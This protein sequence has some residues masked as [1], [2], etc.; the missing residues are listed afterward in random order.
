MATQPGGAI[1]AHLLDQG[2]ATHDAS[3][4]SPGAPMIERSL[5]STL[6]VEA[7]PQQ[8]PLTIR[9]LIQ[10][11]AHDETRLG[12]VDLLVAFGRG[13]R[14]APCDSRLDRRRTVA[15]ARVARLLHGANALTQLAR[16]ILRA[17]DGA[18]GLNQ[19]RPL[20]PDTRCQLLGPARRSHH[21]AMITEVPLQD[22]GDG[23]HGERDE[24]T[25]LGSEALGSLNQACASNLKQVLFVLSAVKKAP[26][27][28]LREP[29]V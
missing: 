13:E 1:S 21:P 7:V 20:L 23:G 4:V 10:C 25:L 19:R 5:P 24:R 15:V 3:A 11:R 29:E 9:Q 27:Q 22:P 8:L 6:H 17:R 18:D 14:H 28:C 26:R 2:N 12:S 16:Q